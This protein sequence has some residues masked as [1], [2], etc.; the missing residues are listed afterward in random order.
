[1]RT[2][3]QRLGAV[4]E[5]ATAA[6]LSQNHYEILDRNWRC[7]AGELDAVARL[8]N[9]QIVGIEVKTRTSQ[10]FGTGFE[11]ITAQK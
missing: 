1:M 5:A 10:R 7:S 9:G 3:A 8:G 11:A 4:G 6:Y 2:A